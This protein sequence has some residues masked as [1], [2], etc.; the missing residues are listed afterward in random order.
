MGERTLRTICVAGGGIVAYSAALAFARALPKVRVSLLETRADPAAHA[1]RL[2]ASLPAIHR[3][4]AAIGLNEFDL[5][6]TGAAT[7]LLGT[8]FENW[9]ANGE[10]WLHVFGEVG[11]A[12]GDAPFHGVWQ[13]AR[14]AG[15]AQAFHRYAAAAALAEAGKFVHP[16]NDVRSP[17]GTFL[18]ALRL[19]PERY[20]EVLKTAAAGIPRETGEIGEIERRDDGGVAA[21]RLTDNRGIEADLYVD[22]TGRSAAILSALDSSWEDWSDWLPIDRVR[23]GEEGLEKPTPVD[24]VEGRAAG[25]RWRSPL[26]DRTIMIDAS[27]SAFDST[28][29]GVP[30]RCGRRP[31]PWI[32]NVLA[33]GDA[34]VTVDPLYG[35]SL[36]L[37]QSAILLALELLPGRDMHP[38]ELREYGRRS[39]LEVTR[40]RDFQAVHYLRSGRTDAPFWAEMTRRDPPGSLARTLAQFE[41]RGRLP[42]FEEESFERDSWLQVLLG[43]GVT[44]EQE[45]VA[46]AAIDLDRASAAMDSLAERFRALPERFPAYGDLLAR[47]KA[48]PAAQGVE[49]GGRRPA[50]RPFAAMI[51]GN[52]FSGRSR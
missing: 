27:V 51:V 17:L 37:A 32:H 10:P 1:D 39:D 47:M 6:R 5:V 30:L 20:L 52:P 35:G 7:H 13:R 36:H 16:T 22:C 44:P 31:E 3:F 28:A 14:R 19:D 46:A 9:S 40:M 34:A 24:V 42:F 48:G 25:W 43:L 29:R 18:Y 45:D 2:P 33:L 8:R 50:N 15:K 11:L 4:H 38:L 23:I 12:A 21:L 26:A 49:G 41:R